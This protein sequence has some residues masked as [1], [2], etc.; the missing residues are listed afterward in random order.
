LDQKH[1]NGWDTG[2][3]AA[4]ERDLLYEALNKV[5]LDL[6]IACFPDEMPEDL[7]GD[8]DI[9][10]FE[11]AANTSC[12]RIVPPKSSRKASKSR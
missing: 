3:S 1:A 8:G 4:K 2:G 5:V 6:P 12:C 10:F 7:D 9:S 11:A